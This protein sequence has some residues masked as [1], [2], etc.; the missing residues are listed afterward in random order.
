MKAK[1][2]KRTNTTHALLSGEEVSSLLSKATPDM[3]TTNNRMCASCR[4]YYG[5]DHETT[6]CGYYVYTG[7]RRGCPVGKCDKWEKKTRS[8]RKGIKIIHKE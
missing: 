3:V 5:S 8:R 2:S 4:Y 1:I 7:V 6:M